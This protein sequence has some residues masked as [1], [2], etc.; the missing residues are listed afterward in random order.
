MLRRAVSI[1]LFASMLSARAAHAEL[2]T[3][4]EVEAILAVAQSHGAAELT[5]GPT[6]APMIRG[7]IGGAAYVVY[8]SACEAGRCDML[9]FGAAW[10]IEGGPSAADAARV[11]AWNATRRGAT[12]SISAQGDVRLR[13]AVA[14][15]DGVAEATLV[16]A[17][18]TW[19][20]ATGA[21]PA[22]FFQGSSGGEE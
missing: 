2:V 7:E 19:R 12:A 8:F 21:F 20:E 5:D 14:L 16:D 13:R 1:A 22:F 3:G 17:F 6:G 10:R 18:R 11:N 15:D 4:D 9:I